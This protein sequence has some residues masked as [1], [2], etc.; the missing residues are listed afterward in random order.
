MAMVSLIAGEVVSSKSPKGQQG[1][2]RWNT[3]DA[4]FYF[5]KKTVI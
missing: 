5:R 4:F 3:G 2:V 1:H